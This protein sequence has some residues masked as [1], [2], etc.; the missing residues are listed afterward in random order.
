MAFDDLNLVSAAG[1]VP[2]LALA[3]AA[4]LRTL[5]DE[6]LSVPT[7]K[8]LKVSSLVGGLVAGADSIDDMALLRHGGMSRVFTR[9]YAPSTLVRSCGLTAHVD[10]GLAERDA[11]LEGAPQLPTIK[12]CACSVVVPPSTVTRMSTGSR[13]YRH[14]C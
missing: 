13:R 1:L 6:H 8:G 11:S 7:D 4:G 5:A 9:A 2:V 12:V 3:E 14:A 10:R